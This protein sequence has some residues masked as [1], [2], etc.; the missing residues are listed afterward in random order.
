[1]VVG[2]LG[3]SEYAPIA[4][5]IFRRDQQNPELW[6]L[7]IE[8]TPDDSPGGEEVATGISGDTVIVAVNQF[9]SSRR[10]YLFQRDHGGPDAWGQV[11]TI[12][13]G[14]GP[15][16]SI[17]TSVVVEGDLAVMGVP[18]ADNSDG[19]AYVFER[20]QGGPDNWGQAKKI[21]NPDPS[22]YDY[23]G[24]SVALEDGTLVVGSDDGLA[25]V[26]YRDGGGPDNWGHIA[27]LITAESVA[28]S[29][30]IAVVGRL[31]ADSAYVYQRH[32]GGS[33]A[34]GLVTEISPDDAEVASAFGTAVSVDGSTI[35]VGAYRHD[36]NGLDA[37]AVYV[38]E[39]DFGGT[40]AWGQVARV[41]ASE[42]MEHEQ[43]GYSTVIEGDSLV[44]GAPGHYDGLYGAGLGAVHVFA[45]DN[46]GANAWG[47]IMQLPRPPYLN[48]DFNHFGVSVDI[49]D[50]TAV[51]GATGGPG[52]AHIYQRAP[53]KSGP[54]HRLTRITA[55]ND[56]IPWRDEFGFASAI[57]GD[58]LVVG[59]YGDNKYDPPNTYWDTGSAYIFQRDQGGPDNWGVVTRIYRHTFRF[60]GYSVAIDGDTVIVGGEGDPYY[61]FPP[62]HIFQR[63]H[64]GPNAWGHVA[65]LI[66]SD[67]E[68]SYHPFRRVAISGDIAVLSWFNN[69]AVYM[70]ER[71]HGGMNNWGE[72]AKL[73]TECYVGGVAID[74]DTLVIGALDGSDSGPIRGAAFVFQR[75]HGGPNAWGQ[76]ATI[77][78]HD[79][80]DHDGF[81][82]SV[83][84]DGDTIIV[85]KYSSGQN[86]AVYSFH[87]DHGGPD[88][89]GETGKFSGFDSYSLFGTSVS[90]SEGMAIVGAYQ[91]GEA[92]IEAGAAY[93]FTIGDAS[94][95]DGFESGDTSGW[96]VTVP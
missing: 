62:A 49:E 86:G 51:I 8:I 81:G 83:S 45:R 9:G 96:S 41:G 70:F 25:H 1:M 55:D 82:H 44:V 75:D 15:F 48:A 78:P 23:F 22:G 71:D 2:R 33:D 73:E 68:K 58:T 60:F 43:L 29:G 4:V 36:G 90:V 39:R 34:W 30:D 47:E 91:D 27:A 40:D 20:D 94:F 64:T 28:V 5:H 95:A 21:P 37:G 31:G 26:F 67:A 89:W 11:A 3:Y 46:G 16:N 92:G 24:I 13:P 6:E 80:A 7:V 93:I 53:G 10:A 66:P 14:D 87:R 72:T 42:P 57:S 74:D 50:E 19:A 59:A 52:W 88:N 85:G 77:I 76:V 56:D 69:G 18:R 65:E 54:W 17:G 63:D 32:H 35:A 84:I 12:E 79:S 61:G 38:F